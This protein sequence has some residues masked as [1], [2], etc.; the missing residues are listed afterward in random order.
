MDLFPGKTPRHDICPLVKFAE[1]NAADFEKSMLEH[2]KKGHDFSY[3][4]PSV[5]EGYFF[6]VQSVG[7]RLKANKRPMP[8]DK[9]NDFL[10]PKFKDPILNPKIVVTEIKGVPW[11]RNYAL[12]EDEATP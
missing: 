2:L 6:I 12:K 8:K 1:D 4:V 10:H 7:G 3:T 9:V 11:D 5:K